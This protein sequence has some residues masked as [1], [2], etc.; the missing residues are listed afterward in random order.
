M[1][2][3]DLHIDPA[4][5]RSAGAV[6]GAAAGSV[7]PSE[8]P[9]TPCA[10][11]T[12]STTVAAE[13]ATMIGDLDACTARVNSTA[14][15]AGLQ[16]SFNADA[17]DE[18]EALNAAAL[19]DGA[20]AASPAADVR[21]APAAPTPP[22]RTASATP[23]GVVP[24]TGR[25]VATLIHRGAGPH[26][27]ETVAAALDARATNLE[28][29]AATVRAARRHGDASWDSD[30]ARTASARLAGI[31]LTY[32]EQA[33]HA[34]VLSAEARAQADN[35]RLAKTLIPPPEYFDELDRRLA[36]AS[37]ANANPAN[38][39]SYATTVSELQQLRAAANR[40]ALDKYHRYSEGAQVQ[41]RPLDA[42]PATTADPVPMK[43][44]GD[45][46]GDHPDQRPG[47]GAPDAGNAAPPVDPAAVGGAA[48]TA[49]QLMGSVLPAVAGGVAGAAGGVLGALT[50]AGAQ[51]Q[52]L[53]GELVGGVT[54]GASSA[55]SALSAGQ[56]GGEDAGAP[57]GSDTGAPD[58]TAGTGMQPG[59]TH[60]SSA[61][62][63]LAPPAASSPAALS[64]APPTFSASAT[65]AVSTTG[66]GA[67]AGGAMVPP[68]MG[69]PMTGRGAGGGADD[70]RLYPERRLRVETPPN[71]EPVKGRREA[72]RSR[73]DNSP[74][75]RG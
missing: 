36:V 22:A 17:Y 30:A 26:G 64:S 44:R 40:D 8:L 12:A 20:A 66:V 67:G 31:E 11:D 33:A 51:L 72:R 52:G 61:A 3:R 35:F 73:S 58:E 48:S 46:E 14:D 32:S 57:A 50:G 19:R 4:G 34:R 55:V 38:L 23:P 24:T 27:L 74:E 53:G 49:S 9:V 6:V 21:Y 15:A 10:A 63:A 7:P 47:H 16:L 68:F 75:D 62:G 59:D 71:S 69:A 25:E 42:G 13:I 29:A 56:P 18:Q 45:A 5:V 60:P 1:A 37:A 41:A 54:Q 65:P 28:Q 70:R 2:T 39:G 43:D